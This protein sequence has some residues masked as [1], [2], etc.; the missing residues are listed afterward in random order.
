[1]AIHLDKRV[2]K[3]PTHSAIF[4]KTQKTSGRQILQTEPNVPSDY[5]SHPKSIYDIRPKPAEKRAIDLDA[6]LID[7]E[8]NKRMVTLTNNTQTDEFDIEQETFKK[9]V[10]YSQGIHMYTQTV[11]DEL[12]D[13]DTEVMPILEVLADKTIE[14]SIAELEEGFELSEIDS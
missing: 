10:K 1:M 13:F 7:P 3:G 9:K 6:Y 12:F 5:S 8:D 14:Q 11:N 2:F 4:V